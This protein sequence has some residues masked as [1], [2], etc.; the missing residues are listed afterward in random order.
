M[1]LLAPP[2]NAVASMW[3]MSLRSGSLSFHLFTQGAAMVAYAVFYLACDVG[4]ARPACCALRTGSTTSRTSI[5]LNGTLPLSG[6]H[7]DKQSSAHTHKGV[8]ADAHDD[9]EDAPL[10]LNLY[11]L[12][13]FGDNCLAVYVM[14]V[15]IA[16]TVRD[17]VPNDSPAWYALGLA[18][19]LYLC[20]VGVFAAYLRRH[21]MF[22]RL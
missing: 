16:D 2:A 17:L 11:V 6:D 4:C 18:L 10:R 3:T 13:L 7:H 1:P 14:H 8:Y 5:T 21:R 12:S 22:L 19:P 20:V 9:E 15:V